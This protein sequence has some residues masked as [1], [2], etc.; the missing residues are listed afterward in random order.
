MRISERRQITIPKPL[1][2]R[3]GMNPNVEVEITPTEE[4][5]LIRKRPGRRTSRG[6]CLRHP[7]WAGKHRRLHRGDSGQVSTT[8]DTGVLLDVFLEQ[9]SAVP[10]LPDHLGRRNLWANRGLGPKPLA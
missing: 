3:F 10:F 9:S 8:V 7:R 5:L 1:R 6:P 2:E 4:G